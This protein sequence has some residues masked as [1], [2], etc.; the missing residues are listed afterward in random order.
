MSMMMGGNLWPYLLWESTSVFCNPANS[1]RS[2]D[3]I[4]INEAHTYRI[5]YSFSWRVAF[6]TPDGS[7]TVSAWLRIN[8]ETNFN[9]IS[10][11][12]W[13]WQDFPLSLTGSISL[14]LSPWDVINFNWTAS[15][16]VNNYWMN[17]Y[18]KVYSDNNYPWAI[19]VLP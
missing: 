17:D 10:W 13:I 18:V 14:S 2:I 19:T 3:R 8:S 7:G 9:W 1:P 12:A 16:W 11:F 15:G 4:L 6:N 5:D